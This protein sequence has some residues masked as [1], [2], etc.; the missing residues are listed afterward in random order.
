MCC[1]CFNN[2]AWHRQ[3]H[4]NTC[5]YCR[6]HSEPNHSPQDCDL[7]FR[8]ERHLVH[9]SDWIT[10]DRSIPSDEE[11]RADTQLQ[12]FVRR[13][14]A[15]AQ[16]EHA[17]NQRP[18]SLPRGKGPQ[19]RGTYGDLSPHHYELVDPT[20]FVRSKAFFHEGK[21]FAV[22]MNETAGS[23]ASTPCATDY[24]SSRSI[25]VVKYLTSYVY[26]NVRRFI[27]V[28]QK[29]KFFFACP[30]YTY[31][32]RATTKYGVRAEEHGIAFTWGLEPELITG[33]TG[34]TKPSLSVV[35]AKGEKPLEKA[36]RIYYGIHHPIQYNVKAKEIG[37]VPQA[38]I[39]ALIGNWKEE[40]NRD[41]EQSRTVT[42]N[43]EVPPEYSV[44]EDDSE[45]S[46]VDSIVFTAGDSEFAKSS[47]KE[48]D[49]AAL[50]QTI[51]QHDRE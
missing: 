27:V 38:Q 8:Y 37:Y 21:V 41:T 6:N 9:E 29:R 30:I 11:L 39:A 2:Y 33:E 42:C 28:R 32:G 40:D 13:H 25:H 5:T 36:S 19:I 7:C 43:A 20:F 51:L 15:L 34:I 12:P 50:A 18:V 46:A 23:T 10:Y 44:H 31:A 3:N 47:S 35:M 16:S 4:S 45:S 14:I 48:E 22:I 49:I 24:N 26:T 17:S 1:L